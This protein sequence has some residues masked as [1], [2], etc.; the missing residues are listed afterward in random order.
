MQPAEEQPQ[1]R[2]DASASRR[3]LRYWREMWQL[4]AVQVLMS[5]FLVI[6]IGGAI[7]SALE[8]DTEVK[9]R[10]KLAAFVHRL[11]RSL[12]PADLDEVG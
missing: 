8:K 10:A 1:Q 6:I 4:P 3:S 11:N 9:E 5:Y 2:G 7:F 12:L